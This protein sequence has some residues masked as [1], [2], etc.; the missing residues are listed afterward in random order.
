M[1]GTTCLRPLS[2]NSFL[3][4]NSFLFLFFLQMFASKICSDLIESIFSCACEMSLMPL[5][6]IYPQNIVDPAPCLTA[7]EVL[8]SQK[9]M[10]LM[11]IERLK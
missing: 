3:V 2:Y 11:D 6:T 8:F 10:V 9:L 7:G 5:A 1:S 4:F